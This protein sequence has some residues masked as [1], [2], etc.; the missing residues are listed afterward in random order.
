MLSSRGSRVWVHTVPDRTPESGCMMMRTRASVPAKGRGKPP[1]TQNAATQA[2]CCSHDRR[3]PFTLMVATAV[4]AAAGNWLCVSEPPIASS[5]LF[6]TSPTESIVE[7]QP[8]P[9]RI[10]V[11]FFLDRGIGSPCVRLPPTHSG[12]YPESNLGFWR[13]R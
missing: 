13:M 7:F 1:R 10:C 4:A 3:V 12:S 6:H 11:F 5:L 2:G 8:R 9:S